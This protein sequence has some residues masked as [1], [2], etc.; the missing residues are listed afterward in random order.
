VTLTM[1]E[2]YYTPEQLAQLEERRE[3]L[4]EEG[5][6]TAEADWAA[7]VQLPAATPASAPR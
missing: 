5:M 4:G 3:T 1:A 7:L 2:K 6:R